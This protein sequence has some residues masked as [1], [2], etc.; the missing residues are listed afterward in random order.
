MDVGHRA[1][2]REA[3]IDVNDRGSPGLGFHDPLEADRMALGH[4][5]A[6]DDDAIAIGKVLL[7]VGG[8][9]A[10]ERGSQTGNG[11]A[12]SYAR[13]ILDLHRAHGGVELRIR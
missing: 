6:F 2:T 3:R 7:E 1:G 13:L 12:V 8:A 11:G 9:A 10:T 5:G 4:V